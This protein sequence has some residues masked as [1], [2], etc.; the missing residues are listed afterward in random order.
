MRLNSRRVRES[1]TTT[2]RPSASQPASS[3][4]VTCGVPKCSSTS[5]PNSFDGTLMPEYNSPPAAAHA[6]MPPSSTVVSV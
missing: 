1:T 4:A 3:V 6:S 2:S 5:S